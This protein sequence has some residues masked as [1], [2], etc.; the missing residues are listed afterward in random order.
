MLKIRRPLGRLIF[1]MGI[2]IPGKIVFLIETAP[3]P[4]ARS[5]KF[6]RRTGNFFFK[7]FL[8]FMFMIW[9]SRQEDWQHFWLS[10]EHCI[11]TLCL[12]VERAYH[13]GNKLALVTFVPQNEL[14]WSTHFTIGLWPYS[15]NIENWCRIR[16]AVFKMI[17]LRHNFAHATT[18]EL[19]WHVQNSHL[20]RSFESN[21]V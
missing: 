3:S 5:R 7:I 20:I 18:A 19:S 21:L 10:F 12:S 13:Q 17:Q 6:W 11:Y 14:Q 2:A 15:P 4:S 16:V 1:N 9:D 8:N